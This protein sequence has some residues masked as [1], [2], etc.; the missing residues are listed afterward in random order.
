MQ[1]QHIRI[2][3]RQFHQAL[4]AQA[5]VAQALGQVIPQGDGE[6]L[7]HPLYRVLAAGNRQAP[8]IEPC[9]EGLA[10][11]TFI[12]S[13]HRC[14]HIPGEQSAF[15][16]ALGIDDQIVF[17][18]ANA[19]FEALPLATLDGLPDVL[20]PATD[21]HRN[22][23]AHRRV[24]GRNFGEAFFHHPVEC[25]AGDGPRGVG[26]RRQRMNHVAQR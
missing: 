8:V 4:D 15:Q 18:G 10:R 13:G 11:R 23:L 20:A 12:E 26:Q 21:R 7:T 14:F 16:Q 25:D 22:H 6:Q 19:L 1:E 17:R 9:G 5:V 24:P 2:L 3:A